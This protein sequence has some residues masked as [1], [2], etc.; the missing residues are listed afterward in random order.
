MVPTSE[1]KEKRGP[2]QIWSSECIQWYP[3]LEVYVYNGRVTKYKMYSRD[4]LIFIDL[5][6]F[7]IL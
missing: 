4:S 7:L 2:D 5:S 3:E 1:A 6:I